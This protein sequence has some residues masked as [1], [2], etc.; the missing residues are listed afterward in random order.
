MTDTPSTDVGPYDEVLAAIRFTADGLV[1][2]IA[3]AEGTGEILMMAW[4]NR[5][6]VVETLRLLLVA[7]T[8]RAVAQGRDL[9]TGAAAEGLPGGLRRRHPAAGRRTG[10]RGLP[11]RPAQLLLSGLEERKAGNHPGGRN[12]SGHSLRWAFA[13][14]RL[15]AR[16]MGTRFGAAAG[17]LDPHQSGTPAEGYTQLLVS[18]PPCI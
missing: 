2:A 7:V 17:F 4:M 8:R 16:T 6:A 1:P 12:R 3:Q 13:Q 9:R 11:H 14:P 18:N 10:R 5:D 15:S